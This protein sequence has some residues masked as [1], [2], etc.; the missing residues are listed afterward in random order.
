MITALLLAA[1]ISPFDQ[2]VAAERAFAAASLE[3]GLH[4]A[5]LENL[6]QDAIIFDPLPAPGRPAHEGQPPSKGKLSWGPAWVAVSPAGDLALSTG[7]WE[8]RVPGDA[9]KEP[10]TGYF[11][12]VWRRQPD[13]AW[14]VAVDVGVSSPLAFVM[15]QSVE[16]GFAGAP[17]KT[18][19]PG[20]AAD[21]RIGVI[22]AERAFAAAAKAGIGE[23]VVA[24]ADPLVR[25]YREG[26]AAAIGPVAARAVLAMDN[27]T[28]TCVPDRILAS[29]AGD[30]GYAYGTC[31]GDG[32]DA[33]S[34]YG[35]LHVWRRQTDG[36]WKVLADVTP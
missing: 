28:V 26:Q 19:R 7:P 8:F 30:L 9:A 27:R 15:P 23:A 34:K 21:A 18:P 10:S 29:A 2:V 36:S 14:K 25:V 20:D 6:A 35:F 3:K 16:N 4:E 12:S 22:T 13:G 33:S 5:F 31:A 17:A 11:F 24:Q 1:T 32:S